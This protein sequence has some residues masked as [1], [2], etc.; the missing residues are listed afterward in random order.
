MLIPN[1]IIDEINSHAAR[2]A[3]IVHLNRRQTRL[4][5]MGSRVAGIARHINRDIQLG[6]AGMLYNCLVRQGIDIDKMFDILFKL[7]AQK[8]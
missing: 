3:Q 4:K 5:Q 6:V 7:M 1:D 8:I 2:V